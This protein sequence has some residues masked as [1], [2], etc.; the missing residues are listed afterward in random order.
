MMAAGAAHVIEGNA[1]VVVP[2]TSMVCTEYPG[3]TELRALSVRVNEPLR[4]PGAD[5]VKLMGK[6][7]EAPG[8]SVPADVEL[9]LTR[10][11]VPALLLSSE[12]FAAMLGLL[13][14]AGTGKLRVALPMFSTVTV[15]GLSELV[16]PMPVVAKLKLGGSAKSSFETLPAA[17]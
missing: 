6:V 7:Q 8:A 11:H 3:P 2:L 14:V 4:L 1:C 12:K 17:I 13:P 5:G 15:F 16:V 9:A 10:G